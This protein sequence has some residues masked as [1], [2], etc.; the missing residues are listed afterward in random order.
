MW[1]GVRL[2]RPIEGAFL[3]C[4]CLLFLL[5]LR[6]RRYLNER[7]RSVRGGVGGALPPRK[8]PPQASAP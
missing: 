2:T 3:C 4:A 6:N 8:S 5:R 1:G 7:T